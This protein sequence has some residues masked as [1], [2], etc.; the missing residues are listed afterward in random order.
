M[1]ATGVEVSALDASGEQFASTT[2]DSNGDYTLSGLSP[3]AS[4]RVE[5]TPPEGS[6]LAA[7]FYPSGLT[8]QAATPVPVTVGQTTPNLDETLGAGGSPL[9]RRRDRCGCSSRSRPCPRLLTCW[10]SR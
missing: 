10:R 6:S 9:R 1:P 2:T 7:Q 5:F 4:Y 8:L 3:S